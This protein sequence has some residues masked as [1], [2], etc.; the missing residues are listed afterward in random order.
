[1]TNFVQFHKQ[2]LLDFSMDISNELK[3][4]F[5]TLSD[6]GSELMFSELN[7]SF[8][9]LFISA[10]FEYNS[11]RFYFLIDAKIIYALSN[12]MLG[13]SGQIETRPQG[14]FTE[15]EQF[16]ATF[17]VEGL[18]K[19]YAK[20][21]QTVT[22]I[23]IENTENSSLPFFPEQVVYHLHADAFLGENPIG[24]IHICSA[25]RSGR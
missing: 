4:G 14:L 22:L 10:L 1:M 25:E 24:A 23:R 8:P 3:A 13:G 19:R 7:A 21:G 18:A 6:A 17:F 2:L 16:F 11:E 20:L 12:R 5:T 15:A 9:K